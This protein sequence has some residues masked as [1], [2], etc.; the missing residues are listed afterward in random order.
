MTIKTRLSHRWAGSAHRG[1]AGTKDLATRL[2]LAMTPVASIVRVVDNS[3]PPLT[4]EWSSVERDEKGVASAMS[5]TNFGRNKIAIN[6][7]PIIEA[8]DGTLDDATAID[9]VSGFGM[10]EASH[11]QYTKA[12]WPVLVHD[13]GGK[14]VP[15]F[16]PM[17]I[18]VYLLNL[19]EDVRIEYL[20]GKKWPGFI[21]YFEAVLDYMWERHAEPTEEP[22]YAKMAE[23]LRTVYFACRYPDRWQER[24]G[25]TESAEVAWWQAWQADYLEDRVDAAET[26]RRGLEH[27][28]E[29]PETQR[30][31]S[32]ME[33]EE[34]KQEKAED[35]I[36]KLI[37]QWM[38][39][40]VEGAPAVCIGEDGELQPLDA[41][42]AERVRQLIREQL[43]E[44]RTPHPDEGA[45][46]PAIHVRKPEE[47]AESRRAF[48]GRPNATVEAMR[49]ALVFRAAAPEHTIKLQKSGQIDDEEL[50]RF[51]MGDMRVYS[52]RIVETK[53]EVLFGL[54]VDG[55]GSMW[56]EKLKTAQEL[57]QVLIWA[58]HD[59]D[60]VETKVW[61]HTGDTDETEAADIYRL[62]E[63]GDPMSRLGLINTLEHANN[64]DSIAIGYCV[65][66]MKDAAQPQKVL[67]VLSDGI[68]AGTNY[69]GTQAQS[70]VRAVV[71]WARNLGIEVIQI[72]IDPA[73]DKAR[74]ARMFRTWIPYTSTADLPKQLTRV[75]ERFA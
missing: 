4:V 23:R 15:S 68:P 30:E 2:A 44:E 19:V 18:A 60:G 47:T 39:E 40:G 72:A 67:V 22:K 55:S 26:I 75:L 64:Y 28:A 45:R 71:E 62:W 41:E 70:H 48:I 73:M 20:T 16:R 8:A 54:L 65:K 11:A 17:R 31:M 24:L 14:E 50:Y 25:A 35:N 7:V 61:Y 49:A 21:A 29:D 56:G 5:Y 38:K 43:S 66:E 37:E 32:G 53:P 9:V 1:F 36:R 42:T 10:H 69:G 46:N 51:G 59:A 58:L 27:L 33:A 3:T 63:R 52:E 57:A 6:P 34:R 12:L 74:Q 13:E